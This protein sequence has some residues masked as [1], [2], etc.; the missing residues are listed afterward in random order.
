MVRGMLLLC[1][2]F[3]NVSELKMVCTV[4]PGTDSHTIV[5]TYDLRVSPGQHRQLGAERQAGY[6]DRYQDAASIP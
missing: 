2:V 6:W 1:D 3:A 5:P 4:F